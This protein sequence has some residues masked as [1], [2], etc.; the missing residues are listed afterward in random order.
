MNWLEDIW[1]MHRQNFR[2]RAESWEWI[3]LRWWAA[4]NQSE[5]TLELLWMVEKNSHKRK[6]LWEDGIKL[7]SWI[8]GRTGKDLRGTLLWSSNVENED[9]NHHDNLWDTPE[10][11]RIE[12]LNQRWKCFKSD[13]EEG[14]WLMIIHSYVKLGKEFG[15]SSGKIRR[16]R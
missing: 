6:Q 11:R 3:I 14:I 13:L 12:M 15:N 5:K 4:E 10:Q 1:M 8:L 9:E 16:V 2:T 7:G